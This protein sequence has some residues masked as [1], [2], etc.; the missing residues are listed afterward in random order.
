MTRIQN[1]VFQMYHGNQ[2]SFAYNP[3]TG[4]GSQGPSITW[5]TCQTGPC[6]SINN[7]AWVQHTYSNSAAMAVAFQEYSIREFSVE[8]FTSINTIAAPGS[9]SGGAFAPMCYAVVDREDAV[10]LASV[11][12]ALAYP[13][14]TVTQLGTTQGSKTITIVGPAALSAFDNTASL[15][16]TI[17]AAGATRSPWLSC[18]TNS[19]SDSPANI[20]HGYIKYYVDNFGGTLSTTMLYI[21]FVM[22]TLI[23]YRGVD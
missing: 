3:L 21:T 2:V 19:G 12:R 16:G 20:P 5:A 10:S 11:Q 23:E 7:G 1:K 18:G 15:L 14:Q 8:M 4:I 17:A 13:S 6:Y 9:L 22:R